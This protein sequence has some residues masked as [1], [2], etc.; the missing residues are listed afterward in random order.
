VSPP[1]AVIPWVPGAV[2]RQ[3]LDDPTFF[4]ECGGQVLTR[5]P[6]EITFCAQLRIAGNNSLDGAGVAFSPLV[7]LDGW[8]APGLDGIDPEMKAWQIAAAGAAVLGRIRN[9]IYQTMSYSA[10]V[11]EGPLPDVDT[12]RGESAP[13]YRAIVRAELAVHVTAVP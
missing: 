2:R 7:Q 8:C 10:R 11:V 5:L 4:A 1:T 3:L 13:L 9:A 12:S 6:S